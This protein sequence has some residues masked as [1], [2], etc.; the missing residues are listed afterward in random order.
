MF[1]EAPPSAGEGTRGAFGRASPGFL[2]L[3]RGLPGHEQS[4]T[5]QSSRRNTVFNVKNLCYVALN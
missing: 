1:A 5:L 2:R 4:H 3:S